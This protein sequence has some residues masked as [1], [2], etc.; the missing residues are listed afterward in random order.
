MPTLSQDATTAPT[1]LANL[2]ADA[3]YRGRVQGHRP[4]FLA[5]AAAPPDASTDSVHVLRPRDPAWPFIEKAGDN[6]YIWCSEAGASALV[7]D[8][9]PTA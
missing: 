9:Q 2:T 8:E 1:R 7:Y 3:V 4:I 5:N 6:V